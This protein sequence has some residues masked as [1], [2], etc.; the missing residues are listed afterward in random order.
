MRHLLIFFGAALAGLRSGRAVGMDTGRRLSRIAA[1]PVE[2]SRPL[3]GTRGRILS[4]D[5]VVLAADRRIASLAVHYRYLEDPPNARWLRRQARARVSADDPQRAARLAAEQIW[6]REYRDTLVDQ[7]APPMRTPGRRSTGRA[8]A[9]PKT[10]AVDRRRGQS[11]G[12]RAATVQSRGPKAP[13]C[14]QVNHRRPGKR[15]LRPRRA[16]SLPRTTTRPRR[17]IV[18]EELDHHVLVPD[19]PLEVIAEVES[20]PEQYPGVRIVEQSGRHYPRGTLAAN[21][22]GHLGM[23]DEAADANTSEYP[24]PA[25]TSAPATRPSERASAS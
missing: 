3:A 13:P 22:V 8:N 20:H 2:K 11:R 12:R 15:C 5:G 23:P 24:S 18:A 1:R 21:V 10:S 9:Y 16:G 14:Q 17:I 19:V 4:R 7:L 25:T 6:I